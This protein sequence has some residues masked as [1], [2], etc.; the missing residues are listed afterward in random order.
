MDPGNEFFAT[1]SADRTIK[2]WDLASGQLKL[3]LTG[4]IEQVRRLAPAQNGSSPICMST[5][6]CSAVC[7]VLSLFLLL[8]LGTNVCS[9]VCIPLSLCYSASLAGA[10][11]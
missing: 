7:I 1:G 4:H 5:A 9:A 10:E 2:I 8:E 6:V 3:T 11:R